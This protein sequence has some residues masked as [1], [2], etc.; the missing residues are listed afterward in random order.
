MNSAYL[1]LYQVVSFKGLA[2]CF[3][4][5]SKNDYLVKAHQGFTDFILYLVED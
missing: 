1:Q 3:I 2:I 5:D 4:N